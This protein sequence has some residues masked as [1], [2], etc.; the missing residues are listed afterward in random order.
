[1]L[2]SLQ[3]HVMRSF[4]SL[5]IWLATL[6]SP[7]VFSMNQWFIVKVT[8]AIAPASVLSSLQASG[9]VSSLLMS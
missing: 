2:I 8:R 7:E 1:M 4:A 9:V 5:G 3:S 6:V